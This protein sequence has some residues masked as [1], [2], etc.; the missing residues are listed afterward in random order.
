MEEESVKYG[1]SLYQVETL[2]IDAYEEIQGGQDQPSLMV[3]K[4]Y[5]D[6]KAETPISKST[7]R[8]E[9]IQARFVAAIEV[10][11]IGVIGKTA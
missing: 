2:L 6:I 10:P 9:N 5:R 1:T 8:S 11:C 4:R 7:L 3:C